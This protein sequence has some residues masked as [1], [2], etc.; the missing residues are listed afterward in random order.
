MART[1]VFQNRLGYAL[2]IATLSICAIL[3]LATFLGT[4]PPIWIVPAFCMLGLTIICANTVRP[5][6]GSRWFT[7]NFVYAG[8][9]LLVYAAFTFVYVHKTTGGATGVEIVS[10]HYVSTYKSHIIGS[11]TEREY[12]EFPSL[13]TRVLSAW[14]AMMAAFCWATGSVGKGFRSSVGRH[15]RFRR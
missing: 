2:S 8:C 4:V 14:F 1:R 11:A 15:R 3:H 6:R 10:G 12:R 7:D 13:E 5:K 9:A